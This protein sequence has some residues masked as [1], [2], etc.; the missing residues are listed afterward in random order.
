MGTLRR[1]FLYLLSAV[2]CLLPAASLSAEGESKGG[3]APAGRFHYANTPEEFQPFREL[4][5]YKDVFTTLPAFRGTGREK[6]EPTYLEEVRIGFIGPL[7][8]QDGPILPPGFRSG[9]SE[10]NPKLLFG[11]HMLRGATLAIEEANRAGG[12]KGKPFLLV[13]RTD[14]V[15]WGQTSNEL[16]KFAFEDSVW[17]VLSG[18]DSNH[19]HVLSRTTL[20]TEV[21]ILNAGSTDPT[22]LEHTIPWVVRCI[23][24]D[25]QNAYLFLDYI[26]HIKGFTRVA[27]LRVND[28]DSR[29]G[30]MEFVQGARRLGHPVLIEKRFLNGDT[31]FHEQLLAIQDSS[32]EAIVL[33]G[34]PK[35]T[36]LAIKQIREMGMEQPVF[37]FDRM[38][39]PLFL[40]TAGAAAEGVVVVSTYNPDRDDPLWQGFRRRYQERFAEEPDT[41]AAHAYDGM[42]LLIWAI[43]EAGLNRA[44][45]RDALFSLKTYPGV[46]GEIVF[47]TNMDDISPPWLAV[48]QDGRFRYFS[49]DHPNFAQTK[50]QA[51]RLR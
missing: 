33:W 17:A 16:V 37:G 23:N 29:V 25:R 28:R 51:A 9:V 36:A 13:K 35:E 11:R 7:T 20:K 5:P 19:N 41:Y 1:I 34:N 46:T 3:D 8:S 10:D 12:Y 42:N 2:C 31:D 22:L 49:S 45:I 18:I 26:Y 43:R 21:P 39:H 6:P 44:L 24:D 50:P 48:V 15:L 32:P 4:R 30:V 40:Q 14:L 27:V 47:D 38:A